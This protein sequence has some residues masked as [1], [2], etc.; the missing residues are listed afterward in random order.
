[1]C[2]KRYGAKPTMT[3]ARTAANRSPVSR[4]AS[5]ADAHA[6]DASAAMSSPLWTTACGTPAHRK[7]A[8][9]SPTSSIASE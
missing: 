8:P 6:D 1:M 9:A 3:P 2:A 7:G 4:C 5:T